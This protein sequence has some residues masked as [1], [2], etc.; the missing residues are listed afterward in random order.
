MTGRHVDEPF[1]A[2][3]AAAQAGSIIDAVQMEP[4]VWAQNGLSAAESEQFASQ[5]FV[6]LDSV[7]LPAAQHESEKDAPYILVDKLAQ[8]FWAK[9][10]SW[11][12]SRTNFSIF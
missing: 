3:A 5:G 4:G 9:S 6:V 10:T 7:A 1:S 8:K 11:P 2:E 12:R